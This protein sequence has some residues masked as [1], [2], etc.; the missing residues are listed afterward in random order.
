MSQ[1]AS[2]YAAFWRDVKVSGKVWTVEDD[3]GFPAPQTRTGQRA[4]PF[5]SSLSRV[6]K[7][8]KT[9]PAYAGFRPCEM[10]WPEMRD[11]WLPDLEESKMLVGVNWSG[12]RAVGYDIE[13][14]DIRAAGAA[15]VGPSFH[16][17]QEATK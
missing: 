1:A 7:I 11:E 17:N 8:I 5:W 2:Q 3:G 13:P 14:S 9:V 6:K 4:M 15:L 16:P 12:P 10:T